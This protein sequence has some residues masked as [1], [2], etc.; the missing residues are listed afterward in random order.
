MAF[1]L[2]ELRSAAAQMNRE[3]MNGGPRVS[4]I[5]NVSLFPGFFDVHVHFRE[6]GFSYKETIKTGS[7]AAAHGGFTGVATMPNLNPVPDSLPHLKAEQDI[8][9]RDAVIDCFPYASL[10]VGEQ[11]EEIVPIEELAPH[12]I[13]F[14]DDGQG[15][16]TGDMMLKIMERAAAVDKIVCAHCEIKKFSGK[17]YIHAGNYARAHGHIGQN[18]ESETAEIRRDIML[19]EQTGCKYHV[20]HVSVADGIELVRKAKARGVDVSCETGPHYVVF[21]DSKIL[22]EGRFK[23]NPPLRSAYDR[24]AIIAGIQ[25]GTIDMIATDHAPH[26]EE[27]KAKGLAGSSFGIVGIETSFP[28][29]YTYL[30]R[31]GH[32]TL[33][34][35]VELMAINP[36]VRFGAPLD[37]GDF[38]V[39][40]LDKQ[41]TVNP[42]EFLSKGRAT[43]FAGTRVYGKC[44]LTVHRGKVVWK[45]PS[46]DLIED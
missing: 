37:E 20:C 43:P 2:S 42:D 21:D 10:T 23:M 8:I 19:A 35:L 4:K 22:E 18:P 33:D 9:D 34:K 26:S 14:S 30:V 46:F 1:L 36:R 38:T 15:I 28:V 3:L 41:Y 29:C 25:D 27:E 44:L 40:D 5:E 17:G 12:V 31:P 24:E 39:F 6:P 16:Q 11:G 13:G 45:D 7:M 32:I